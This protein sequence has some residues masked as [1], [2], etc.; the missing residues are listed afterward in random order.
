MDKPWLH[1]DDQSISPDL[2][3]E[4]RVWQSSAQIAVLAALQDWEGI[5]P[6]S[7]PL[8][9]IERWCP[10]K[11]TVPSM[12]YSRAISPLEGPGT[13]LPSIQQTTGSPHLC[14]LA[15]SSPDGAVGPWERGL[16]CWPPRSI[17]AATEKL[18][19]SLTGETDFRALSWKQQGSGKQG[20]PTILKRT[21][22]TF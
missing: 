16:C 6:S 17:R 3:L 19:A 22:H 14:F 20:P 21:K 1:P 8:G 12:H 2:Q 5:S 13:T 11:T 9:S 10:L 7:I 4:S 15:V 18:S